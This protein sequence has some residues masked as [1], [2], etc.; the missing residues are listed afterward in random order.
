MEKVFIEVSSPFKP[1]FA[2]LQNGA[3]VSAV[4]DVI[5]I[6]KYTAQLLA[7]SQNNSNNNS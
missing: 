3:I 2:H 7:I 4:G 5:G 6:Q 1:L